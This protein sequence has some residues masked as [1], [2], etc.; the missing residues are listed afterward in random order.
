MFFLN[1][2]KIL[3]FEIVFE[4]PLDLQRDF[5][6]KI[7]FFQVENWGFISCATSV[8]INLMTQKA[9]FIDIVSKYEVLS[10]YT[11]GTPFFLNFGCENFF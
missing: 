7:D 11:S 10:R 2:K 6:Q 8:Q 3:F 1:F 9:F 4:I 5:D